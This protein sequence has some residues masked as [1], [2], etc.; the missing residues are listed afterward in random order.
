MQDNVS[1]LEKIM[2]GTDMDS[3]DDDEKITHMQPN[4]TLH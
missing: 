1:K 4:K 3:I 2:E